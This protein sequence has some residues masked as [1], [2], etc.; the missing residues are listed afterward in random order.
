M[1][2]DKRVELISVRVETKVKETIRAA[3]NEEHRTVS[4]QTRKFLLEALAR[5]S[6]EKI[7]SKSH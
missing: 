5:R 6:A 7:E 3:A 4:Q 2:V 1:P